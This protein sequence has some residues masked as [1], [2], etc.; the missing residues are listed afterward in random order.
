VTIHATPAPPAARLSGTASRWVHEQLAGP[1]REARTVHV[2][3]DAVYLDL[4]GSCLGVLSAHAT[5]VPCGIKTLAPALTAPVGVG[6]TLLVGSGRIEWGVAE[7]RVGRV[8]DHGVPPLDAATAY[9]A[10]EHLAP[11]VLCELPP[12]ALALLRSGDPASVPALLGLGG[13]LTPLGDDVLAGWV[14]AMTA[15]G[16][17][18]RHAV[19][20][21]V[22]RLAP[23]RT[24]LLSATLLGCAARGDVLPEYAAL[25]AGLRRRDHLR[26]LERIAAVGHTSGRGMLLGL[27]LALD[28]ISQSSHTTRRSA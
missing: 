14:A 3:A 28:E 10:R 27:V 20:D 4:D 19:A 2:G 22:P 24:T 26:A 17:D 12:G 7:V 16:H 1:D 18:G 6:D 13:G 5:A 11:P 8:V 9:W 15:A 21:E 25:V 23:A